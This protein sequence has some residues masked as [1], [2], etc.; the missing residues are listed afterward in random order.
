MAKQTPERYIICVCSEKDYSDFYY[1][2]DKK[3][4]LATCSSK[5]EKYSQMLKQQQLLW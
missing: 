4:A 1:P 2:N 3:I 5:R